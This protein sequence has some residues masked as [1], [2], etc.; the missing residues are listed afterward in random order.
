MKK[1]RESERGREAALFAFNP[2]VQVCRATDAFDKA[3]LPKQHIKQDLQCWG[4]DDR[5]KWILNEDY[6][7]AAPALTGGPKIWCVTRRVAQ[8]LYAKKH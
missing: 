8:C 5:P 2:K 7:K 1:K 3:E 4:K 6:G